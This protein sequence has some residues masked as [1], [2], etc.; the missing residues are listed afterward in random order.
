MSK[1]RQ[2]K[3]HENKMFGTTLSHMRKVAFGDARIEAERTMARSERMRDDQAMLTAAEIKRLR[4]A[5]K[6]LQQQLGVTPK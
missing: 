1:K 4:K 2:K 6:L 3:E 5:S